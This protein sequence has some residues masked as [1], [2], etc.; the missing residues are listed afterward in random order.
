MS[1]KTSS[2]QEL[3]WVCLQDVMI[4]CP[5][6]SVAIN[7]KVTY[8]L[9]KIIPRAK[10]VGATIRFVPNP[11]AGHADGD[12]LSSCFQTDRCC[13]KMAQSYVMQIPF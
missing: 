1:T 3:K 2:N 11:M 6:E 5:K 9:Q 7:V 4:C 10:Q 8:Q 12:L 13:S